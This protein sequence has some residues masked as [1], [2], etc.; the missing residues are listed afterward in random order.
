VI[1]RT[2]LYGLLTALL[3]SVYAAGVFL[4]GR[5][6]AVVTAAHEHEVTDPGATLEQGNVA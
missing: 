4:L 2:L 3:G 6:S 1:N 5:P